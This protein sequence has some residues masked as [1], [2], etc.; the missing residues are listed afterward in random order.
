M[1]EKLTLQ[2]LVRE[3]TPGHWRVER[4]ST[5]LSIRAPHQK[6]RSVAQVYCDYDA[7]LIC[8][9]QH[10]ALAM[11]ES[12]G[13]FDFDFN[14]LS[15]QETPVT[16]LG[17]SYI[18]RE[19][20]EGAACQYRNAILRSTKL[21]ADGKPT[22]I[23]GLADAE[24]ILISQCLYAADKDG[25]IRT[26]PNGDPDPKS[27]VPLYTVRSWPSRAVKPMF[28]WVKRVSDL[29]EKDSRDGLERKF[30][31][32]VKDLFSLAGNPEERR[33]WHLWMASEI[34]DRE[35]NST[36]N[37]SQNAGEE[38]KADPTEGSANSTRDTSTSAEN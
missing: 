31:A 6:D 17:K 38:G 15:P 8:R 34:T 19:A 20:S 22:S 18:L 29:E 11:S 4:G 25:G 5:H 9:L 14:D 36:L 27:L 28:N 24:P 3:G 23:E 12:N 13:S 2:E 10:E 26:T 35:N 37:L 32:T 16:Y 1:H 21:G 30:R 33:Q 7:A